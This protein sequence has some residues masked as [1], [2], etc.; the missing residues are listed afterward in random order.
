LGASSA[1]VQELMRAEDMSSTPLPPEH[2]QRLPDD[3]RRNSNR[4]SLTLLGRFMR[5]T[6]QEYPCKLVD[7]SVSGAS[8][9]S[10][11]AVERGERIVAYFDHIGALEGNVV[12]RHDG[13]FAMS[14]AVTPQR[15]EKLAKRLEELIENG[16]APPAS[17]RR[18][19]LRR[20]AS[21][22]S[23]LTL[24]D[25][26]T[27]DCKVVDVA[28]TGAGLETTARPPIGSILTLGKQRCRAVRHTAQGIAVEFLDVHAPLSSRKFF[29]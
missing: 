7:I 21:E 18:Q 26:T 14:L 25:G 29:G 3:D 17:E 1:G 4:Y 28:L 16:T 2:A 19:D 9:M 15:R 23:H 13:G 22:K 5:E 24:A 10:P 8:M 6:K 12:R 20:S 27:F 11:V